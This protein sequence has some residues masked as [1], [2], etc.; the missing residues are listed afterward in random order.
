MNIK[1]Y[2]INS[3]RDT[4]RIAFMRYEGLKQFQGKAEVDSA[5]YDKIYEGQV[6]CK[7]LED[8][9]M[10]FNLYHPQD[11]HGH[12]LSVSDIVE[13]CEKT[14]DGPEKGYYFCDSFGFRKVNEFQP[15][16]CG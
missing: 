5:I 10:I 6:G 7:T 13:V 4:K 12:S 8:V 14:E 9:Y 11:F 2:Q 1:I 16:L 3:K 15:E